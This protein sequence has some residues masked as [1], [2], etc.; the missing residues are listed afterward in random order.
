MATDALRRRP[1]KHIV[2]VTLNAG[3]RCMSPRKRVARVFQV[4]ELRIYPGVHV[5]AG[6]ARSG[7]VQCPMIDNCGQIVLLVTRVAVCR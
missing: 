5:V 2:S 3:Q 4:V 1:C 6:L 7:E